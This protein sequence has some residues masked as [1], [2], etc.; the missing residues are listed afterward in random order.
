MRWGDV[1]PFT[2]SAVP[3]GA[4]VLDYFILHSKR[5]AAFVRK[6][7]QLQCVGLILAMSAAFLIINY[8]WMDARFWVVIASSRMLRRVEWKIF[9]EN[10]DAFLFR[11]LAVRFS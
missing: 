9:S 2:R 6:Q 10:N 8:W 4:L 5:S 11:A 1:Y 3:G 7:R